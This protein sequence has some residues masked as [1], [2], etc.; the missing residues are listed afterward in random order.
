MRITLI[1]FVPKLVFIALAP[2]IP[3]LYPYYSLSCIPL[4]HNVKAAGFSGI[5]VSIYQTNQ[6]IFTV[7]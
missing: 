2:V 4:F 1:I 6:S 5:L 3:F 7:F